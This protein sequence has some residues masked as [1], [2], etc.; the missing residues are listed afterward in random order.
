V[1]W[2][3]LAL[4]L[5]GLVLAA[6]LHE[7]P[8]ATARIA[9]Q[10]APPDLGWRQ[11]PEAAFRSTARMA[12]ALLVSLLFSFLVAPLAAKSRKAAVVLVPTLD[13]LQSIPVLAFVG[14]STGLTHL[15]LP[16]RIFGLELA[17]VLTIAAS[18]AWSM[19]FSLYQSLRTVPGD[20][21]E[22]ARAFRLTGWQR[23]WRLEAPFALPGL[24]WN[25]MM[26]LA[27]GWFYVIGTEAIVARQS[28]AALPGIG[29]YL[30][31][32]MAAGDHAAV[33]R[34]VLAM[35]A[36]ILIVDQIVFRPLVAWSGRFRN[37]TAAGARDDAPFML[38]LL[39]TAWITRLIGDAVDGGLRRIGWWRIGG[40]PGRIQGARAVPMGRADWVFLAVLAA[41][42]LWGMLR[43]LHG[44]MG[45]IGV[46]EF[47]EVGAFGLATMLRVAIVVVL[48][49][50]IWVPLGVWIGL[51]PRLAR[52]SRPVAQVLA[53]FPANLVF[54]LLAGAFVGHGIDPDIAAIP[55]MLLGAQWYVLFNVLA[56][57]QA[58][59]S[60]L[61]E[62][63]LN[64]RVRGLVWWR[65]VILPGLLPAI[66]TGAVAASG[67]AWNSAIVAEYSHWGNIALNAEGIGFY[68]ARATESGDGLRLLLGVFVM[69][70]FVV[71]MNALLWQPLFRL[72]QRRAG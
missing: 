7:F 50:A 9:P 17:C 15:I 23:F 41:V 61:R 57:A 70:R 20:L 67:G 71:L 43:L 72:A 33:M 16:G 25:A 14:F 38:R 37:E 44:M 49:L 48:S 28:G 47:V 69:S 58:F 42:G 27:G 21:D 13:V 26:C 52:F 4:L 51:R 32:A 46:G 19:A 11:L 56:G 3:L 65:R 5:V 59:P 40:A 36:T 30:A 66:A 68:I 12:A 53:S 18:Q 39:R 8:A 10:A 64:F 24:V 34:A 22:A 29:L 55:L 54:P 62:V 45:R 31:Q 2:N 35:L 63:A 1:G 60:D 6:G